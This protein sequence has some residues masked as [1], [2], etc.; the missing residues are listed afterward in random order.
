MYRH[1]KV[2]F[3]MYC[4]SDGN[5]VRGNQTYAIEILTRASGHELQTVDRM[6]TNLLPCYL[7]ISKRE[8]RQLGNVVLNSF[9]FYTRLAIKIRGKSSCQL[10]ICFLV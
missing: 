2:I 9:H 5:V 10:L 3:G 6:S 4:Y 8:N 7:L 1:S